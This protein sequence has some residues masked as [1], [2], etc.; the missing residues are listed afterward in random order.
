[1]EG[2][3]ALCNATLA[4]QNIKLQTMF[5]IEIALPH[6]IMNIKMNAY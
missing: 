4:N 5:A 2:I 3:I 6:I 1:M